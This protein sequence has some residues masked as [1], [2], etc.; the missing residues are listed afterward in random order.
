MENR[1]NIAES[2]KD[3]QNDLNELKSKGYTIEEITK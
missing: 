2:F 1:I 3:C